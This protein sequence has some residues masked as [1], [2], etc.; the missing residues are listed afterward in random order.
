MSHS[1]IRSS[2][3]LYLLPA[4]ALLVLTVAFRGTPTGEL[5]DVQDNNPL[6]LPA[7]WAM[8]PVPADN[9]I[10]AEK[11]TLG[12]YLFYEVGLSGDN[13]TSC[14]TCHNPRLAFAAR[15]SHSGAFGDSSKPARVV[16]RLMNV[17]YD[18]VLTWDGHLH[19]LEE[20]VHVAVLKKGDLR[21]DTVVAFARLA[22]NPAYSKLFESAFGDS[23]ITLDR[24]AM[25][26][27]TFERCL[28]SSSSP[29][30]QYMAGDKSAMSA[31]AVRGMELFF[32]TTTTNCAFCHN[33][34][35]AGNGN[36]AGQLFSDNNYYRTGTFE[37]SD[38]RNGGGYGIDTTNRDTTRDGGRAM[39]TKKIDDVGKFRT[40]SLRN[41]AL[42]PPFGADGFVTQLGLVLQNY[43]RG[44]D[45]A[46]FASTDGGKHFQF[47]RITNK[48]SRIKP[49]NL[50]STQLL[51]LAAFINAL[52]DYS[53]ISNKE[54]L[55]PG[56]PQMKV[57]DRIVSAGI[58]LYPNPALGAVTVD[59][60]D[61]TGMVEARVLSSSGAAVW[62][63]AMISDGSLQ[64]EL[65]GIPNG[66]Y[67][68]ELISP[69]AHR[70]IKFVIER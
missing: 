65:A 54:Y 37:V 60:P 63:K 46:A 69:S 3:A 50:D 35:D 64:L 33:S 29:Y 40:P 12:R 18:S 4:F 11:F 44:G 8:P 41:V 16:P 70:A 27:A 9:P 38:P 26:I 53:F 32:D 23:K 43:N 48:A 51:D 67:R 24:I 7:G 57:D 52:T 55:D 6:K 25:A 45:T 1:P 47:T 2:R 66:S 22:N 62:H 20:Q 34:G 10:T 5:P 59:C 19:S 28:I 15:G 13:K 31:S 17:A 21:A 58:S 68:L 42:T 36:V 39:V 61:V 49:L 30:D 14:G 56:T